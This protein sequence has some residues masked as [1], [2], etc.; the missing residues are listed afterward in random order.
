MRHSLS[1]PTVTHDC[2]REFPHFHHGPTTSFLHSQPIQTPPSGP[3][4]ICAPGQVFIWDDPSVTPVDRSPRA[5]HSYTNPQCLIKNKKKTATHEQHSNEH[6]DHNTPSTIE[7]R[8]QFVYSLSTVS[9]LPY[10]ST[11]V[12]VDTRQHHLESRLSLFTR[13]VG[14]LLTFD[15]RRWRHHW[16]RRCGDWCYERC[17][18][19]WL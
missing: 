5:F 14:M 18:D 8:T 16:R 11:G 1:I 2:M 15:R 6:Y 7:T 3:G 4:I 10:N 9:T 19:R 13:S 12:Q 17:C